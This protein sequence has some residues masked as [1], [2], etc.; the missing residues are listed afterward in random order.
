MNLKDLC[1]DE[2]KNGRQR[3]ANYIQ[4]C[5]TL[6]DLYP[7]GISHGVQKDAMQNSIDA[8]KGKGPL[9]VEFALIENEKG[10]F[11]T[12]TD[13]NTVGLTGPVLDVEAYEKDLPEGYHWARF[14]S[15]AFTKGSPDAIGARG[16]GKFIFLRASKR[17]TMFYDSLRDDDG[18]YRVGGTRATRND[19]PIIPKGE[20]WEGEYGA[21]V[22]KQICGMD[23][24][25]VIGTRIII[26][27][28]IEELIAALEDGS[29]AC[30]I[31]ETWFRAI[32][33]NRAII[34]ISYKGNRNEI[35]LPFPYPLPQSDSKDH[36]CWFR[37]NEEIRLKTK[38]RY[39]IKK[40]SAVWFKSGNIPEE[41]QGIAI[42]HNEMK[43]TSLPM[44][45]APPDIRERVSGFIEFDRE[46]NQEI[47]KGE[48]QHPNHYDLKWKRRIPQEIKAYVNEQLEAFG[49]EKLNL[50]ADPREI[51][52]R[53]RTN[54]EEWAMRQ[55]M[56][57]APD[58]DLFGVKGP[59]RP[60]GKGGT[61]THPKKIGVSI[62]NF[63]F[64]DPEIAPRINWGQKFI[65]LDVIAYNN[66]KKTREVV[67]KF[68]ILHGDLSILSLIDGERL[69]LIDEKHLG[70]F[71]VTIE[72]ETMP[73]PDEYRLVASLFDAASGDKIDS[74]ARRFWVEKDPTFKYP[75]ELK[76]EAGFPEPYQYR[77]WLTSGDINN[78]AVVHYNVEHPSY[79]L[80]ENGGEEQ[81]NEYLFQKV[82]L[83]AAIDFILKRPNQEDGTPDYHPL[84]SES[85]LGSINKPV[86][87]DEV[88]A[89]TYAEIM[90]YMS[91]IQWHRMEGE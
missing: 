76:P 78:S 44:D 91:E 46:L 30:A 64:P 86:E 77:Q 63:S 5:N 48:N 35:K 50:G 83:E 36:K 12:M 57:Y 20:T 88:P 71:D 37:E 11:F 62:S 82:V 72:K 49:K 18:V 42:I 90:R 75:F 23:R 32:E 9:K 54:A 81:Q 66:T 3:P 55:L 52:S 28:P 15:F 38:E 22:L 59:K 26:V 34:T 39:R 16:Q 79:K 25:K 85:I 19:C 41:M 21:A 80:A 73:V 60:K 68:Q 14:E 53:R 84:K 29:F 70:T 47:R 27:D 33:K 31:Q 89:K 13:S 67:V 2:F 45:L 87:R 69:G 40:F 4:I 8:V 10:R 56:K 65:G 7:Q 51:K 24:L 58:L 74:V 17:Y 1:L 43:I 6:A 61:T